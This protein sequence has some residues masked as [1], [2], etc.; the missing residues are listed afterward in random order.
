MRCAGAQ[1]QLGAPQR[2]RAELEGDNPVPHYL[3]H[4]QWAWGQPTF[5]QLMQFAPRISLETV[6]PDVTVPLL[7]LHGSGDRQ[8]PIEYAYAQYD[9]AVNSLDRTLRILTEREG[10]VEHVPV[11]TCCKPPRSCPTGSASAPDPPSPRPLDAPE[12]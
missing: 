12:S 1:P 3:E 4:A 11:T 5:E 6:M 8:I 9:A 7:R 10:G 2:R